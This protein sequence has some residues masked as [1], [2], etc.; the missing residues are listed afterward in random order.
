VR[1]IFVAHVAKP[2]VTL[3]HGQSWGAMVA[4]RAA[5]MF[6]KSWNGMLLTSGIVAGPATYD[7]RIDMRA[8]YQYLCNNHPRGDEPAYPLSIGL[9]ADSKLTNAELAARA[10]DC[11]GLNKP[12]AQRS[13]EQLKKIKTIVDVIR[14]PET[15][16][17]SHLNWGTFTLRDVVQKNGGAPFGNVGVR[18]TG[19][20]DDAV[21]NAGISRWAADPAAVARFAKDTDHSGQFTMPVLY[22]HAIDDATAFVE[23]GDTL[24]MRM[25]AAGNGAR[26]VQTSVDSSE[27]SYWGD[28]HYPPLFE[29][30]LYWVEKNQ[31]PTAAHM[32][33]RCAALRSNA[34]N[35]CKFRPDYVAKPLA[36]RIPK[37]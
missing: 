23:G 34:P 13:A 4:T 15:S 20:A 33:K 35:E 8:L 10:N 18:Y 7:F 30:L 9:P 12:A 1:R 36:S 32:S 11:L 31:I 22:A 16:I 14:V 24:K 26:L 29:A 6:P 5:E 19:S 28:A 37:R 21:L 2:R 25:E 27:H 17:I 3:L